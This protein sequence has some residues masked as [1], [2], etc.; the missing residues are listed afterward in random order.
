MAQN[1]RSRSA[2][3]GNNGG[4]FGRYKFVAWEC[5][6]FP[7]VGSYITCNAGVGLDDDGNAPHRAARKARSA[8]SCLRIFAGCGSQR[9]LRVQILN[10]AVDAVVF[11]NAR[12]MPRDDLRNGVP[13][14]PI[15]LLQLRNR[16]F[17]QVAIHCRVLRRGRSCRL[18]GNRDRPEDR[19]RNDKK[20]I[21]KTGSNTHKTPANML[22]TG[23]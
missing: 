17:E 2:Q 8:G 13:V 14:I 16:Y 23:L 22:F 6:A 15:E 21:T 1:H 18:C 20:K 4:V 10:G 7:A 11:V 5:V 9:S 3:P 12:Q 19:K